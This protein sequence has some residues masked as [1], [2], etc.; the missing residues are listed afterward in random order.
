M[1]NSNQIRRISRSNH[2]TQQPLLESNHRP[3]ALHT[4][5]I[6]SSVANLA[7]TI[8]GTGMLAMPSVISS[9]G[10]IPAVILILLSSFLSS[11]GLY[12]LHLSS[13]QLG[14]KRSSSFNAVAN[15]TYPNA[16][17]YF[18]IAIALKCFGVAISY[19]LILGQLLPPLVT[20]FYHH[21]TPSHFDPPSALLSRHFWISLFVV[22][23]SPLA[24][25]RHL[26]SL[27]YTSYI[28]IFSATYLLM[29]VVLCA[30]HSPIPLPPPGNIT[31]AKFDSSA[32]SK[33]P[34]L[35]FAFTC[36]QNFYPVKNELRSN[37]H[38]STCAVI[39]IS[40]GIAAG[41]YQII[42]VLGY[43]TFGDKVNSNIMSMYPDT[44]ILIS[45]GRLAIAVLVLSSYPLQVH[46][47]RNSLDKIISSAKTTKPEWQQREGDE[48]EHRDD[49]V[50][51]S[52]GEDANDE[53]K[54]PPP[55][56]P[57]RHSTLT[58]LILFFTWS[59]AMMV[60]Q[61]DKVLAFVGSTG[62]TAISFI[63]PGLFYRA[64]SRN[65]TDP[66]RRWLRIGSRLLIIYGFSVMFFCLAFNFYDMFT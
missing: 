60:S 5:S 8:I 59:I 65:D 23:L 22:I 37:S 16:A 9:T 38:G 17:I 31:W 58:V 51:D 48:D 1:S 55:P 14:S 66:S 36:A 54:I 34:V 43:V 56:S 42:G 12:L 6:P 32:I 30:I 28:S 18:D 27:R 44:S 39:A 45:F 35:V 62:S 10:L 20:S 21:L 33:F 47:C 57:L 46:P 41:L 61:L 2:S 52:D 53:F 49:Q 19:L 24:H 15:I 13:T 64:L 7:N 63:L 3:R 11:F 25:M 50:G 29:I 26:N 4:A 40:I